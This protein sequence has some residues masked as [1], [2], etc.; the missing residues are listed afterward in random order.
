[1]SPSFGTGGVDDPH[2]LSRFVRAQEDD[3][4]RALSEIISGRKR[5]HWMW[6]VFPQAADVR[7]GGRRRRRPIRG[8]HLPVPRRSEAE[9]FPD[10]VRIRSAPRIGVRPPDREIL[11][12]R[13]RR[14]DPPPAS[15]YFSLYF[16]TLMRP[17]QRL[18]LFSSQEYSIISQSGRSV[19]VRVLFHVLVKVFGSS[20][21]TS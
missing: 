10:P 1:M 17:S 16:G 3:Y 21:I 13:A 14:Q 6:Y 15:P 19:N 11:R 9:V 5:T 20:T 2:D 7:G 12:G 4:E 8:R 18:L